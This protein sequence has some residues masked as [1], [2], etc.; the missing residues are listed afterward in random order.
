MWKSHQNVAGVAAACEVIELLSQTFS[1]H[2]DVSGRVCDLN[3][4]RSKVRRNEISQFD[5]ISFRV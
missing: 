1:V 3:E 4:I 5:L 2:Y